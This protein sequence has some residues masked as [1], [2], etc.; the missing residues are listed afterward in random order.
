[1]TVHPVTIDA[2]QKV[3]VVARLVFA[4]KQSV[5][6]VT[7]IPTARLHFTGFHSLLLELPL[8]DDD[9]PLSDDESDDEPLSDDEYDDPLLA[10]DG[11]GL[12]PLSHEPDAPAPPNV[13]PPP[14]YD[15]STV[16]EGDADDDESIGIIQGDDG[17]GVSS[18]TTRRFGC[19]R[20][21]GTGSG[22]GS[23]PLRSAALRRR[24]RRM[25][26]ARC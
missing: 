12:S 6:A 15:G 26:S 4:F 16:A 24:F 18:S 9:D 22:G 1:L 5:V 8:S 11:D 19:A 23:P 25:S 20:G 13:P 10:D 17:D 3:P 2:Q 21:A 7:P 14:L